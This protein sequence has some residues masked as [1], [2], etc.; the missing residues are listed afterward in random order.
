[1]DI[2]KPIKNLVTDNPKINHLGNNIFSVDCLG[3]SMIISL[4]QIGRI[5]IQKIHNRIGYFQIG[6]QYDSTYCDTQ[7]LTFIRVDYSIPWMGGIPKI[8]I[9]ISETGNYKRIIF[10]TK[11]P[12]ILNDILY[13]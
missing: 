11:G 8:D 9:G 2:F 10:N 13:R 5:K 7:D 12:E 3:W 6:N 4:D 1:M